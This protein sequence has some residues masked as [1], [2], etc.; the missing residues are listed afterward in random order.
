MENKTEKIGAGECGYCHSKMFVGDSVFDSPFAN[1]QYC[2]EQC[3]VD[4][5]TDDPQRFLDISEGVL[6][7]DDADEVDSND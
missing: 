2:S 3:I 1:G 7:D 4:M 5:I 6:T